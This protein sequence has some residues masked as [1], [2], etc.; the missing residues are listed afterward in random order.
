MAV[1]CSSDSFSR[2][3]SAGSTRTRQVRPAVTG[4]NEAITAVGV[5]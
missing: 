3:I 2:F 1:A 5:E 4:P